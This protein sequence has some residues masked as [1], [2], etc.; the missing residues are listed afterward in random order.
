MRMNHERVRARGFGLAEVQLFLAVVGLAG[1]V[2]APRVLGLGE[3]AEDAAAR[4][5]AQHL[6]V[7]ATAAAAEGV[8]FTDLDSTVAR[9]AQA[10]GPLVV[11]GPVRGRPYQ[12]RG[13]S[14]REATQAKRHLR[15]WNG[16]LSMD[17]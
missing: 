3:R 10:D 17:R 6:V 4:V 5:R 11:G 12:L 13:L 15:F 14:E 8:V 16:Q 2:A 7:A 1:M 9:L